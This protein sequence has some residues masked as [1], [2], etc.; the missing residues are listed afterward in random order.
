MCRDA[1]LG[2]HAQPGSQPQWPQHTSHTRLGGAW[3][4][5]M[6][7]VTLSSRPERPPSPCLS[8]GH[9]PG[10][11][12]VL[13]LAGKGQLPQQGGRLPV[14][15]QEQDVVLDHDRV[16]AAAYGLRRSSAERLD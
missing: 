4:V 16:V 1:R 12:R 11:S 6:P 8:S 5:V 15:V 9:L 2:C 14:P 7:A 13:L 10:P 3:H